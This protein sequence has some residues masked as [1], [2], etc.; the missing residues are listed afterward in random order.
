MPQLALV[1]VEDAQPIVRAADG[2]RTV[3]LA[4]SGAGIVDAAAA[5]LID[6]SELLVYARIA[7]RLWR[8][9][10]PAGSLL[11]V[12]DSNRKQ[13]HQWRGSQDVT[14]FTED[15]GPGVLDEDEADHRLPVF[16]DDGGGLTEQTLAEQQGPIRATASGYGDPTAT[17]PRTGRTT[18]WTGT[19]PPPGGSAAGADVIGQKLR[20][21]L[22]QPRDL[23][24]VRLVQPL[25]PV[26]RRIT[27]VRAAALR[28]AARTV[29]LDG[30]SLTA[31]GQ[32]VALPP[33][34]SSWLEVEITNATGG[35]LVDYHGLDPVGFSTV[36]MAGLRADEVVRTPS[37]LLADLGPASLAHPLALV[38]TRERVDARKR[39]RDD[40]EASLVRSFTLP[41]ARAF[42]MTGT[43]HLS[44]RANDAV[45]SRLLDPAG[46]T[47][48]A[49]SRL[50]GVPAAGGDAAVDG[51]PA[52]AWQSAFGPARGASITVSR[53]APL[54]V[55]HLDLQVL[56]DGQHSVPTSLTV[57]NGTE[58]RTVALPPLADH[59]GT[60]PTPAP[61]RFPAITGRRL[62]VTITGTR[63]LT[64]FDRHAE[65][66]VV[67]PV[68][69]AE[70]GLPGPPPPAGAAGPLD[71]GCRRDLLTL[72]GQPLPVRITGQRPAALVRRGPH[73]PV[74][75]RL[76]RDQRR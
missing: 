49:T 53:P 56:A 22:D 47:A 24:S 51:D 1:P 43:V 67:L 59:P 72:D 63:D 74:L 2:Q 16:G 39:W 35:R 13:G 41:S 14:G 7:A 68:G 48:V 38:F 3:V 28:P 20:L 52:T 64:T 44:P 71:T 34:R 70:L 19:R 36:D 30:R 27:E 32:D 15:E 76:A 75:W 21:D 4:G 66:P 54:T 5:G 40:P 23:T 65:R 61:V 45:L 60:A 37:A 33:G 6:G 57:S 31:A 42:R 12:T 11:V 50:A 73:L 26:N 58:R 55:D 9:G 46:V 29:S 18:P 62:T 10:R 69:I 8:R 17:A 25:Q